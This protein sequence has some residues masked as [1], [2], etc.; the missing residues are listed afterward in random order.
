MSLSYIILGLLR[1]CEC[2]GYDLNKQFQ[3]ITQHFW[4]TE[5]SQIYR[6]LYKLVDRGWVT[7]ETVLQD[8][9]PNKKIYSTTTEGIEALNYWLAEPHADRPPPQTWLAQLYFSDLLTCD[10]IDVVVMEQLERLRARLADYEALHDML[11]NLPLS[12]ETS[13]ISRQVRL[14]IV[15][16]SIRVLQ[17]EID[18][19]HELAQQLGDTLAARTE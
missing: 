3:T 4:T 11:T 18:Y 6:A 7:Y 13:A 12:E 15:K 9:A 10:Q 17:T 8:D 5:Q 14:L 1:E 19:I 16:H 2:S